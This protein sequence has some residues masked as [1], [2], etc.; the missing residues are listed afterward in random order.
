LRAETDQGTAQAVAVAAVLAAVAAAT[1][2]MVSHQHGMVAAL[3]GGV[4]VSSQV[5]EGLTETAPLMVAL[6]MLSVVAFQVVA[7][8]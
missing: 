6:A 8:T 5:L 2:W 4:V 1:F 3:A 7:T